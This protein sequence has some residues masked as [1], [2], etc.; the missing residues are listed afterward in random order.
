MWMHAVIFV[1][2]VAALVKSA[3]Y[4]VEYSARVARRFQISDLVVGLV[5]TSVGTSLPELASSLSA[6]LAGS[7]G[8]IIGN[9]V[10]SNI[11]NI[12][13]VLGAAAVARPFATAPMMLDRDGFIVVASVVVFFLL[14][15]DNEIGRIDAAGLLL[16]YVAYV[17]FAARS[18]RG[19]V[20]HRFRDFLKFVFDFEYAAPLA[21]RLMRRPQAPRTS[22][23]LDGHVEWRPLLLEL[24]IVLAALAGLILSARFVVAEAIWLAELLALPENLIGLSLVAIGT[25]L[26]ELMVSV[27]AARKG[28]AELIVGNIMGSNIANILLIVG[29][30]ATVAPIS[31]AELSVVY[32]IPIMLFF[33]LA[34]LYF[35][36]S[37]WKV[38]RVQGSIA[39]ASY[40][41][42]LVLAFWQ[43]WG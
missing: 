5:I 24:G 25:S 17:V 41:A 21:R 13:L 37:D 8:L 2:A 6:A 35:V 42:F 3:D 4:L 36:K 40:V 26:P 19:G 22:E 27:V 39:V 7:P 29:L 32:T 15:L 30:S 33:S 31:V 1:V 14:A 18:D 20:E 23:T 11:A 28:K 34:L 38:T 16:I 43:S 10:G 12:G 9:V